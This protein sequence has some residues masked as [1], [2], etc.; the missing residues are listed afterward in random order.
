MIFL[1]I[2]SS[3]WDLPPYTVTGMSNMSRLLNCN[4]GNTARSV[5]CMLPIRNHTGHVT[6]PSP[7]TDLLPGRVEELGPLPSSFKSL[8]DW[9]AVGPLCTTLFLEGTASA[10][11]NTAGQLQG[12]VSITQ[13][14]VRMIFKLLSRTCEIL[15]YVFLI[16]PSHG[17]SS[18]L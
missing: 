14:N 4:S 15:H 18:C 12:A 13:G 9:L 8:T 11:R 1:S 2:I 3:I 16:K 10:C 17:F 7:L 6:T 5:N